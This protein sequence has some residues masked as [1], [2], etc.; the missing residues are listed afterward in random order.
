M[1]TS[2]EYGNVTPAR[3]PNPGRK[4]KSTKSSHPTGKKKKKEKEEIQNMTPIGLEAFK[5]NEATY[6]GDMPS[7]LD[8]PLVE[9]VQEGVFPATQ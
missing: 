9:V 1:S 5:K 8:P 7:H 6:L 3:Y 4:R 2:W